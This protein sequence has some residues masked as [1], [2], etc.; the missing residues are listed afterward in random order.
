L[1]LP[2][3]IAVLIGEGE[4]ERVASGCTRAAVHRVRRRGKP[5]LFLKSVRATT[6]ED[7]AGEAERLGWLSGRVRVPT[8][9]GYARHEGV[10]YLLTTALAGSNAAQVGVQDPATAVRGVGRALASLH[11]VSVAGCPFDERRS[12]SAARAYSN[13]LNGCVDEAEFDEE[14]LGLTGEDVWRQLEQFPIFDERSV[15]THGDACLANIVLEKD[16]GG[17]VDCGRAGLADPFRDLAV[18][19]LSIEG[20]LGSQWVQP[21]FEAYG[22][23]EIDNR[24]LT[25]YRL[26]DEFF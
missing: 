3:Q 26:L 6:C 4:F 7:L 17:F 22:L 10:E 5:T 20:T 14:R 24:K 16:I 2:P 25:F 21:F 12:A 9:V 11:A 19:S 23:A 13:L 15:V 1:F 8:V 18:V